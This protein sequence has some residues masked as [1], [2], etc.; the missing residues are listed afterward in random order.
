VLPRTRYANLR[1]SLVAYQVVGDAPIDLVF[2][3]GISNVEAIWDHPL[4][5]GFLERLAS[6]SRLILFDFRGSGISYPIGSTDFPT[7]EE[8]AEDV[9][10]VLD[11]VGSER[12]ALVAAGTAGPSAMIFA[13]T[14]PQRTS[15]L[16]LYQAAAKFV[17]APDYPWGLPRETTSAITRVI[18]SGWGTEDLAA[19]IAPSM[20]ANERFLAYVARTQR[21]AATPHTAAAIVAY[22]QELDS[23]DLLPLI[24]VPTLVM[25]NRGSTMGLPAD[26]HR[27]LADRI[28]GAKLV[29]LA[30]PDD[31]LFGTPTGDQFVD[32]VEEFLT[33]TRRRVETDRVLATVLFTD[34]VGSTERAAQLGDRKWKEVLNAHDAIVREQIE[35]FR[36][37]YVNTTGDGLLAT[38]D[39]PARAIRCARAITE[40]LRSLGIEI[41]AGLHTGEI[42]LR[43]DNVGGIAVHIGAR[44]AS[45]AAPSEVL[46]SRTVTDLVT[47]SGIE[48]DDRGVCDLKGVPG[49]WR[50]FAVR[51]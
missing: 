24:R 18:E 30:G 12:A 38:F 37:R 33:G 27:F 47:G 42:E 15:A 8:W 51:S 44:V 2:S 14:Y 28:E 6:F 1:G 31:L 35:A 39:G 46:V 41:R 23:R 26:N 19:L 3:V 49:E 5:A 48:F 32:R 20:K 34:I 13:A 40:A 43:G 21:M 36:G 4:S 25:H 16:L 17:A 29:E 7:W 45:L 22:Q 10:V 50:L 11:A 9:L